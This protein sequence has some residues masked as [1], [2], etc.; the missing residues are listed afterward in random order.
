M[1]KHALPAI[2]V[3]L[4]LLCSARVAT[5]LAISTTALL[6]SAQSDFQAGRFAAASVKYE[7]LMERTLTTPQ[8]RDVLPSFCE[9]T[10]REGKLAGAESLA[11]LAKGKL[12]D[13]AALARVSFLK[14]EILY[15][16]GE[17]KEALEEYMDFLSANTENP[18][19]N[20]AIDRLLLIDENGDGDGKPL[21]TYA[22]AEFLEFAG[23]PDSAVATLRGL[24]KS[25]PGSQIMDEARMKMGDILSSQGKFSDAI[26]EY[27]V[28]EASFPQSE[29]VPVSKL[30]VAQLYSDRL[31]DR[32]KAAAECESVVTM[33]PGTSFASKAR[34][35][36][37]K[38]K[39][40]SSA[41]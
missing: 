36:L 10:L 35:Q 11:V 24:V 15:F 40:V 23:M 4:I 21:D 19:A 1:T 6:Q 16:K 7:N 41:P 18:L 9:S 26:E 33:F 25:F 37:Q 22:H 34:N 17:M 29:L 8:L 39:T 32:Q 13:L 5:A 31:H 20:D 3:F 2:A 12:V 28:L 38:L 30:K 27:R 14:G